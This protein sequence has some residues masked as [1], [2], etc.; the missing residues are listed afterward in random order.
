MTK[1]EIESL[2]EREIQQ[3]MEKSD[4]ISSMM[5]SEAWR[6]VTGNLQRTLANAKAS[7][8]TVPPDDYITII[9]LQQRISIIKSF[10]FDT[11][12]F[13]SL[14]ES[15]LAELTR[16]MK[17]NFSSMKKATLSRIILPEKISKEN[18]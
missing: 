17:I 16:R 13:F 6:I 7:L 2:N 12:E 5:N 1:T 9:T 11:I 18:A 3:W 10:L 8:E 14:K 15:L 4:A